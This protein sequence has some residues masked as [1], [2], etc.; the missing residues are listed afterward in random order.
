[1]EIM[2]NFR[3]NKKVDTVMKLTGALNTN[4][5]LLLRKIIHEIEII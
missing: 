5:T 3:H 1:M 2:T 4:N